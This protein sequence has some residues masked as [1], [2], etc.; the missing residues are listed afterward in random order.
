MPV[1]LR[2]LIRNLAVTGGDLVVLDGGDVPAVT[3]THDR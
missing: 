1:I 3:M 2:W